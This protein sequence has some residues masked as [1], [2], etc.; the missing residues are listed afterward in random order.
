MR[1]SACIAPLLVALF[2]M[3]E[4]A[5]AHCQVPCGIYGDQRRF[6]ELLEDTDTIVK[7]ITQIG[8]LS[9]THDAN[10]HNQ[11]S[12]WVA[13]KE[14]HATNMQNMIGQYFL[15]QRVKP[16][17]ENYVE[18]LK[19]AHGVILAAMKC[20]QAA[21]PATGEALR[22]AVHELYRAYT[23]NDPKLGRVEG[24]ETVPAFICPMLCTAGQGK[25][26]KCAVCAMSLVKSSTR[27]PHTHAK[28]SH[29]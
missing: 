24:E 5:V 12:R 4:F 8:E 9:D 16:D 29:E 7:A 21:D 26:G 14:A 25:P 11:L 19:A 13:T 18:Q 6:E 17:A 20:K 10:G 1:H 23:G 2:A 27:M 3:S 22:K 28:H 15:A